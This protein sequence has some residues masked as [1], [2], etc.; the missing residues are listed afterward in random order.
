[1]RPLHVD[2]KRLQW[3]R[4]H[5]N[6]LAERLSARSFVPAAGAGLQDSAPRAALIGLHARVNGRPQR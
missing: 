5:P 1:M 2:A 3:H 4:L 6:H